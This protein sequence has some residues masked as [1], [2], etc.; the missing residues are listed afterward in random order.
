MEITREEDYAVRCVLKLSSAP[1]RIF[2]VSEISKSMSIPKAF[3]AKIM[4]KLVRAGIVESIRGVK[5]GFR[6]K[7]KP[8]DITLLD[9]I[10]AISGEIPVNRCVV[11][12]RSC[13]RVRKCS[14]HPVWVELQKVILDKLKSVDFRELVLKETGKR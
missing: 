8:H 14:V 3:L 9:V 12:K 5:G 2:V 4:Q 13:N 6:L 11:D 7:K 1:E 10:N